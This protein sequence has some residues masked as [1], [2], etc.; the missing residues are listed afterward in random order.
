MGCTLKTGITVEERVCILKLLRRVS[1]PEIQLGVAFHSELYFI[2]NCNGIYFSSQEQ[3]AYFLT[4]E[5]VYILI[6]FKFLR[7]SARQ[8]YIMYMQSHLQTF[9]VPLILLCTLYCLAY[10]RIME[11]CKQLCMYCT[12]TSGVSSIGSQHDNK[13]LTKIQ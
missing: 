6:H 13:I 2:F 9:M 8:K 1:R 7:V 10:A 4:Q 11:V 5:A 12:V 3:I